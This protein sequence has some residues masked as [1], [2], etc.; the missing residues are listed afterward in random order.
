MEYTIKQ[1]AERV[2]LTEYTLRYYEKEGL[3]PSIER[4]EHGIRQFKENDIEWI[5]LI[6]CL[7]DT[8]MSISK[9]KDYVD[10]SI[11]GDSTIE[12]RRQIILNQKMVTEQKIEG[13]NK[14]LDMINKKLKHYNEF[15]AGKHRDPCNQS[16]TIKVESTSE[17]DI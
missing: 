12:L 16:N 5:R 4:D 1:V 9:I 11:E 7:R 17:D 14:N 15:V 2:D 3:L 10:L 8:G 13:M 6:C